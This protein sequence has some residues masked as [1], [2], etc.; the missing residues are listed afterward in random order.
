MINLNVE[1][2]RVAMSYLKIDSDV[3]NHLCDYYN[4]NCVQLVDKSRYY[5][6]KYSDNWCAMFMSVCAH[7]AG[8]EP[9]VYEVS[10][11]KMMD[12]ALK[13]GTYNNV[14]DTVKVG[15][16]ILYNWGVD[17]VPDHIGLVIAKNITHVVVVEGNYKGSVGVRVVERNSPNIECFITL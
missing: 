3:K 5:K 4:D 14:F 1:M 2:C 16:M 9:F 11:L 12:K 17:Y 8:L 6:I 13:N 10:V 7:K 15:D